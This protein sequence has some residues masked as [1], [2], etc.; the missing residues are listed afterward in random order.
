M[1]VVD[2]RDEKMA[3]ASGT[4]RAKLQEELIKADAQH[5]HFES[6]AVPAPIEVEEEP[7]AKAQTNFGVPIVNQTPGSDALLK[8]MFSRIWGV[9]I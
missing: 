2:R 7:K 5:G 9:N 4:N 3:Y 8:V 1:C 6:N